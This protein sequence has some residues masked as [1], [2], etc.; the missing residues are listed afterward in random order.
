MRYLYSLLFAVL[1]PA[2][3][4]RLWLRGRNL[5]AYRRRWG[6]RFA[7]FSFTPDQQKVVWLHTVSVGEFIA[8]KETILWLL[9]RGDVQVVVTTTT[10]TGS[11]QVSK[12]FGDRIFHVYAP[13]DLPFCVI[14][15]L[16][17]IR[18]S[19]AI[20]METE[21]WPNTIHYCHRMNIPVLLANGRM[22]EKS[23]RGYQRVSP[24]TSPMLKK[25]NKAAI[26][27]QA[28]AERFI[29]LG[30][31]EDRATVT[32]SIKFDIS[33]PIELRQQADAL[34]QTLS[35]NGK[36]KIFIAASTHKGEDEIILSAWKQVTEKIPAALLILV[37]RHPD[38]FDSVYQ[39]CMRE[40]FSTARRSKAEAV[41]SDTAILLA[42][43]LGELLML[44]GCADAVFVGGSLVENGGHNFLEPAAWGIPVISGPSTF[45]FAEIARLLR[46]SNGMLVINDAES[47]ANKIVSLF[48]DQQLMSDMGSSAR[49]VVEKNR[50]ALAK[51]K[52]IIDQMLSGG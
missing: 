48:D 32:G 38:R 50:G 41:E 37:P 46:D 8:A 30:L 12:T 29:A 20:F 42:D 35:Q 49:G 52:E 16:K 4:L 36:R 5:P 6:E 27:H 17:K 23:A 7:R 18:P 14:P 21:L 2:V 45:N 3:L 13:Y 43:T 11:E 19:L 25:I 51:L 10:P 1:L 47:L 34:K 28:D 9:Q 26:Q 33:L 24:L 40:G 39:L 22:S 31:P 15:F 44:F